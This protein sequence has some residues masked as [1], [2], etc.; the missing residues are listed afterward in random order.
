ML[1][2]KNMSKAMKR[3]KKD[4]EKRKKKLLMEQLLF[5][6]VQTEQV[7]THQSEF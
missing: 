2:E 7:G 1:E 5:L 4:E 3:S 6:L